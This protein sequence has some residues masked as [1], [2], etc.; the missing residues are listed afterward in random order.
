MIFN[1]DSAASHLDAFAYQSYSLLLESVYATMTRLQDLSEAIL[2]QILAGETS[3]EAVALWMTLNRQM[4]AKLAN[5]AIV[6]LELDRLWLTEQV[7]WPQYLKYFRLKSL[8][9]SFLRI[10]VHPPGPYIR[11]ELRQLWSGLESLKIRGP[12]VAKGFQ[13]SNAT[14]KP[15]KHARKGTK[16]AKLAEDVELT[17]EEVL[18]GDWNMNLTHPSLKTLIIAGTVPFTNGTFPPLQ[19]GNFAFLPRSMTYLDVSHTGWRLSRDD[20]IN[21][22]PQ[23]TTLIVPSSN[24][25]I[26]PLV[27]SQVP[28]TIDHGIIDC[29]PH[30]LTIIDSP[31]GTGACYTPQALDLL[32][33]P[34]RTCLPNLASFPVLQTLQQWRQVHLQHIEGGG[35]GEWPENVFSMNLTRRWCSGDSSSPS[36]SRPEIFVFHH[37]P[38]TLTSLTMGEIDWKELPPQNATAS[39]WPPTLTSLTLTANA[40]CSNYFH[41]LPRDLKRFTFCAESE[42]HVVRDLASLMRGRTALSNIDAEKW[43]NIK[44]QLISIRDADLNADR[45]SD[46]DFYISEVERGALCGLPLTI[47]YLDYHADGKNWLLGL[48]PPLVKQANLLARTEPAPSISPLRAISPFLRNL[49]QTFTI[50]NVEDGRSGLPNSLVTRMKIES[51]RI[52]SAYLMLNLPR[53]LQE[54]FYESSS[55][56]KSGITVEILKALPKTLK[57]LRIHAS[58]SGIPTPWMHLL[59]RELQELDLDQRLNGLDYASLPP[60][61]KILCS[62]LPIENLLEIPFQPASLQKGLH[63]EDYEGLKGTSNLTLRPW[64]RLRQ[65]IEALAAKQKASSEA[66]HHVPY[67]PPL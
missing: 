16:R 56:F 19:F 55:I 31:K 61:L 60:S 65:D 37:L 59:P 62:M 12:V 53:N 36:W 44:Q 28:A 57:V 13:L 8:K 4:Q 38:K 23:L 66:T 24:R 48:L 43:T 45:R 17:P 32:S 7:S 47:E 51:M 33:T 49:H 2:A 5:G 39:F 58:F 10:P 14:K 9:I 52:P 25:D 1:L 50:F 15:T 35:L 11:R 54:L 30:S 42:T 63:Y 27:E 46:I 20:C 6:H 34:N 41:L 29:L 22:P 18:S 21:L 26:D 64:C 3:V 67:V 40:A